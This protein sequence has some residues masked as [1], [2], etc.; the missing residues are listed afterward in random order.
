MLAQGGLTPLEVLRAATVNGARYLGI[1]ATSARSRPA[2]SP[3]WSSS[4]ATRSP[5][6]ATR[7]GSSTSSTACMRCRGWTRSRRAASR[8]PFFFDG[9]DGA[10]M[11]VSTHGHGHGDMEGDE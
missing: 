2:S 1:A 9:V 4:T 7:T 6:S 11:P 3:T 10:A 8:A 5:T